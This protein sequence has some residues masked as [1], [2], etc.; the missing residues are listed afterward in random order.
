MSFKS[1]M[2][3]ALVF[4]AMVSAAYASPPTWL[5]TFVVTDVTPGCTADGNTNTVGEFG[6]LTYRP[7]INGGDPPEGLAFFFTRSTELIISNAAGGYFQGVTNFHGI[8][9]GRSVT[10]LTTTGSSTMTITPGT[11]TANTKTISIKGHI[12]NFF[13]NTPDC[14][15]NFEA[16]M[17]PRI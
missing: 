16:V 8:E 3:S 13:D 5:G 12:N 10:P 15:V 1:L 4:P 9:V 11:I 6:T 17:V 7:I 2:L 14:D